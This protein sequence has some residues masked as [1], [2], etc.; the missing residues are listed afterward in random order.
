M[1]AGSRAPGQNGAGDL[2]DVFALRQRLV[3]DYAE[4]T[5]SFLQIRDPRLAEHVESELEAG[6]LW[7]E[8][9]IQLNPAYEAGGLIDELIESGL[10]HAG[11][12]PI[13]RRAKDEVRGGL[14]MRLHRHQV[15][16][17]EAARRG[18]NYVL[19]TGTGSGKSLAY[20][21]PIVDSVLRQ[22][23]PGIKAIVVYPMNALANSQEGELKKFLQVGFP[24]G[25][26]P[27][28]FARYTG[29]EGDEA[30]EEIMSSPPD[31]LLTNYVMLELMLLRPRERRLVQAA[32]SLR[33]LVLD[34]LHTYR[35]RQGS[36]VALLMRRVRETTGSAHV[37]Y[38]GT[39]ATLASGGTLA[40]QRR[41]IAEVATSLF[42]ARVE[43]SGVIGE[44]LR[45]VTHEPRFSDPAW[46]A[47]ARNRVINPEPPLD[48]ATAFP[49]DPLAAW[50]EGMIGVID[51]PSEGRLIRARPMPIGGKEGLAARLATDT[52]LD[53]ARCE[54]AIRRVLDLGQSLR[55][56]QTGFPLFAYRLHQFFSRGDAV[57][58]SLQPAADR[59]VTTQP[60]QFDPSD[61]SRTRI[62]LPLA[63][64]RECGQ[65]YY[66]VEQAD[67]G[68]GRRFQGR[69]LS[70]VVREDARNK[71]YLVLNDGG[72][73]I[74][75]GD[76]QLDQLP[77]DWLEET[78]S[79]SRRV[80]SSF[81]AKVPE[82][83][84][85]GPDGTP[86]APHGVNVLFIRAP[87][88]FCVRCGVT[89][90]GSQS[91]DFGKLTTLG[92]GGRS[93]ATSLLSLTTIRELRAE[94]GL[95]ERARK[96]LAFMDNRQD[97]S[98]QAGHFNDF[99]QIGLL[100]SALHRAAL[101]AAPSGGIRHDDLTERVTAALGLRT[102]DY[103]QD[104]DVQF[105]AKEETEQALRQ[106]VGY[107][108]YRDLERGWRVTSPNLEQTGLLE[109][110]Y[111]S[112]SE[113]ASEDKVW[114]DKHEALATARPEQREALCRALLDFLRRGLAIQ[115][116]YLSRTALEKIRQGSNQFLVAPWAIDEEERLEFAKVAFPRP[117][118]SGDF[119][120]NLYV[121]GRGGMGR[122]AARVLAAPGRSL[123]T[124]DR[125]EIIRGLFEG[126][127][128]AGL[129]ARLPDSRSSADPGG[130]QLKAAG[131]R[132]VGRA[133]ADA[134]P[135]T[136]PIRVPRPPKDGHKPN[137]Y[138]LRFYSETA[139]GNA[140]IEAREHTAQVPTAERIKREDA[141]RDGRLPI[142]FCSPTMELGVDI[143]DLNVVGLRNV[144]PTPANY[145]Q[146]SGRA[147][148]SGSP[149]LVFNYCAWGV[150]HDQWFYRRPWL[151]V[152]GQVRAPRL[153]LTNQDLIRAH[154]HAVWL[155][156][157]GLDLRTSLADILEL[158]G[159]PPRLE[160]LESVR[161]AISSDVARRRAAEK[162]RRIL[163]QLPTAHEA[164]W[165]SDRWLDD[166]LDAAP[167]R[168][169]EACERWRDLYRSAWSN[170]AYQ[171]A[172]IGDRSRSE[173]ERRR[174]EEVRRQAES[175]L[176][177]LTGESDE[178][179]MQS[180]F[181]SYRYFASEGFLPGYA[182]PRLPLSAWI[183]GRRG[184]AGRND[185]LSRPR[186]LAIS[187]FGPRS[188]VYHEGSRYRITQ[189]MLPA[190][191][192]QDNRLLTESIKHCEVCGYFHHL[193]GDDPGPD[194][195][196]NCESPLPV[197]TDKLFRLRNVQTRRQD[198]I[199]SDEEE[200][201]RLGFEIRTG[202]RY[203]TH[204]GMPSTMKAEVERDG[205]AVA[206]LT[207]GPAANIWRINVGWRR[208]RNKARL[209]FLLDTE[210]GYWATSEDDPEDSE[211]AMSKSEELVI[212][213][214]EDTRNVLVFHP[215]SPLTP[216]QMASIAA[217]LKNAIQA[218]YQLED[219][220]L[221][222][223]PL[224]S[225]ADRRD[226]LFYEAAE[227]GAGVLRRLALEPDAMATVARR[228]L[229]LCHFHPETGDDA[230]H[231]PG[232]RDD[233]VAACYDC[234]MTY[235][236]QRDHA[237]LDRFAIRDWLL[238]LARTSTAVS[239]SYQTRDEHL[240]GLERAAES[241]LEKA[242]LRAIQDGRYA[243]P[244]RSQHYI[245]AA[246]ARPDFL[247]EDQFVAIFIDGPV[248][249]FDDVQER[250]TAA[251]Q[252]L[253]D[254]GYYVLRF[255]PDPRIWSSIFQANPSVFGRRS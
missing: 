254:A 79:G 207:F 36:D 91:T 148:R 153:D 69:A 210:R 221:A 44:T 255:G 59:F 48:T 61:P 174:A 127:R 229:D 46:L 155:A 37:Q 173:Q 134:R 149:A 112:L 242:W 132:W 9:L 201:Q 159:D 76:E 50:V 186:F 234:L 251:Q 80:K 170:R 84:R 4:Y 224:P 88:S 27:V 219:A 162:A 109:I 92:S 158:A 83:M 193:Q 100:R 21:V 195:C 243:P 16:A 184:A 47:G 223:E 2:V 121:S 172:V 161:A 15:D 102:E 202:I 192:G 204:D 214:V 64:C 89:Y 163:E 39:S 111:Q 146:R 198:R 185:Y 24:S 60:Q 216:Q 8:P 41:H 14:P 94:G 183:P 160:L 215:R 138:F 157:T 90:S 233:C 28:T 140:G 123:K 12:G 169:D 96:L 78:S 218:E 23:A 225:E 203:A 237:M 211:D 42:G 119:A 142:L 150:S 178:S 22:P 217:A 10:L 179:R 187:E 230:R 228:A 226:L 189:V 176:K 11:C 212:P 115:V 86:G 245:T 188:I 99:V 171:H 168:F 63:F 137:P 95:P 51:D 240:A 31:I 5:R 72:A 151:M 103:A 1:L 135:L 181:Y 238:G 154:V 126:L 139:S 29:Q 231:A 227:G 247:Y 117:E 125:D 220:E 81:R 116:D 6:L 166:V 55:H 200:R 18:E 34:E 152:A 74:A 52:G 38:V 248:H 222:V 206:D 252:R 241:T 239:A 30:R 118:R 98:L 13:F 3:D 130:Y 107:R 85:V 205:Q 177:L 197:A 144:P 54:H 147:G 71:G 77:E 75:E 35:G 246:N 114:A 110:R 213:F 165:Y 108:I 65:D 253:E 199:T 236:N 209:G 67:E 194:L 73:W 53:P 58:A 70:D 167:A 128:A 249:D 175:Q 101:D 66:V 250:D 49:H 190:E 156:E 182:F 93:S 244:S 122:L 26:G 235:T 180:D 105:L 32:S 136:D 232:A 133:P 19:T 68:P 56:E 141:F 82:Q 57:Y 20:M 196:E 17:I 191:R 131:M 62:L 145:A 143:A 208:R 33:F 164:D 87:L 129:V 106:V 120:G 97:A 7:P 25:K 43:P 113:V 104:P 124:N 40:E 45:R